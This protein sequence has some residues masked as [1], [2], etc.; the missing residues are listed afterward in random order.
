MRRVVVKF[1][2]RPEWLRFPSGLDAWHFAQK[3]DLIFECLKEVHP[4]YI[5]WSYGSLLCVRS[6]KLREYNSIN[7]ITEFIAEHRPNAITGFTVLNE[8][9]LPRDHL[10]QIIQDELYALAEQ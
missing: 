3:K 4:I 2:N 5:S 6:K 9:W 10:E 7:E 8:G 1:R